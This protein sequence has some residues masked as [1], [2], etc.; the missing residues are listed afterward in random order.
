MTE[1]LRLSEE[2]AT[3][4]QQAQTHWR[5][6]DAFADTLPDKLACELRNE[7]DRR[8]R[9]VFVALGIEEIEELDLLI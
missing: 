6:M 3:V 2:D 5:I 1:L 9:A 4:L 7:A 8:R